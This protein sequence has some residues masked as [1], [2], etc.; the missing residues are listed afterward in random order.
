VIASLS[1]LPLAAER[2]WG[3]A[4]PYAAG[5]LFAGVALLAA[6]GAL[7]REGERPFS[8]AMVYLVLGAVASA[9]VD[10]AGVR[11]LDP[12]DHAEFIEHLAELA[13]IVALF[14]AGLR[15][16]RAL[17]WRGWRSTVLL[18]SI[19]MPLT[20]AGVAVF[21]VYAMGLSLGAAILLGAVLAPTDP[22]LASD[23]QVGP[24]GDHEEPEPK[25]A[26]TSEAG[27]NDG[28][29]FPFVFLGLFVAAEDGI[30]WIGEWLV[31]DVLYAI[32]AGI[33][34]GAA[35]G[36]ALARLV[37][38]L[39]ARRLLSPALDGWLAVAAVLLVYGLTEVVGG[40]GFLAAFAG[41]LAFRRRERS[42]SYH[43]RV[44]HGSETVEKFFELALILVL[45]S[46]VTFSGLATAGWGWL[47]VPAL[48]LVIRPAATLLAFVRSPLPMRERVFVGWFGIRGIGS[49]YYVA[50]AL[51]AGVLTM[52]EARQVYWTVVV[53]V[54]IS[55]VVH[56]LSAKPLSRRLGL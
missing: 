17:S 16:D 45:G 5:M 12:L 30:G 28:L 19:V 10:L 2:G 8:P 26:L 4:D 42:E 20:I 43:E 21:G 56:G 52:D 11:I 7:S 54:G 31:A 34:I 55:I 1:V 37:S 48:L 39:H 53:C 32:P 33:G 18:L 24:P 22:V 47:L 25:F 9:F 14:T 23:V 40:Y 3:F 36:W 13:V 27:L 44:H 35:G 51:A 38:R 46:T 49:F 6:V 15:L 41:G 50:V 29:A